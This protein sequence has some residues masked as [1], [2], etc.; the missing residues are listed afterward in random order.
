MVEKIVARYKINN[1]TIALIPFQHP[2][3]LT[4][5]HEKDAVIFV[6]QPCKEI[7]NDA[8]MDGGST[9]NGRRA[10]IV[11]DFKHERKVVIMIDRY[12][13]HYIFL[14]HS[15]DNDLCCWFMYEQIYEVTPCNGNKKISEIKL[16]NG[17]V[18]IVPVSTSIINQQ[19]YRAYMCKTRYSKHII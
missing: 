1:H 10:I 13:N 2:D 17:K 15:P 19:M 9:S 5:V 8:C 18:L 7:I 3:F 14:T 16:M 11:R 12:K 6:K 4:I